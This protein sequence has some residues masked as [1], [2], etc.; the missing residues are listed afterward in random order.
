MANL[1]ARIETLTNGLT[2]VKDE[3]RRVESALRVEIA[4]LRTEMQVGD[5]NLRA[6]MTRGFENLRT[7][8][9]TNFRWIMGGIGGA[10]LAVLLAMARW[11]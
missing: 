10:V 1:D 5:A 7:E 9:H 6:E 8:M 2:E 11:R 3:V 4:G